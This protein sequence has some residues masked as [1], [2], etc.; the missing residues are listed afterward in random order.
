MVYTIIVN[1]PSNS[2]KNFSKGHF[3]VKRQG[4][5]ARLPL[6]AFGVFIMKEHFD[7]L[8]EEEKLDGIYHALESLLTRIEALEDKE[9]R[10][11][12]QAAPLKKKTKID[13]HIKKA[14][15]KQRRKWERINGKKFE[16]EL[17]DVISHFKSIES[18]ANDFNIWEETG[19][20][21]YKPTIFTDGEGETIES[22]GTSNLGT[23]RQMQEQRAEQKRNA[24]I[25][26]GKTSRLAPDGSTWPEWIKKQREEKGAK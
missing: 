9:G 2:I 15:L 25:A 23:W 24:N 13:A 10:T 7:V 11:K 14:F 16:M 18:F 12:S 6:S 1:E 8:S 19:D 21:D 20:D 3:G 17:E 26:G 22:F 5:Y 4:F